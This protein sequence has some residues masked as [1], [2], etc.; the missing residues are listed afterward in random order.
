MC[1]GFVVVLEDI[2]LDLNKLNMLADE[3]T[4]VIVILA[5]DPQLLL[6]VE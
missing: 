4:N 1:L 5:P 2:V 6:K 3:S